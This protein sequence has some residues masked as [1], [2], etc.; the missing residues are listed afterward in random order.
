MSTNL[1]PARKSKRIKIKP[2]VDFNSDLDAQVISRVLEGLNQKDRHIAHAVKDFLENH[3]KELGKEEPREIVKRV[4]SEEVLD[5]IVQ[6]H[7]SG[8]ELAASRLRLNFA[9][10]KFVFAVD[11][12]RMSVEEFEGIDVDLEW[13]IN[14]H[15]YLIVKESKEKEEAAFRKVFEFSKSMADGSAPLSLESI[16]TG[17]LPEDLNHELRQIPGNIKDFFQDLADFLL[18]TGVEG[19]REMIRVCGDVNVA[20]AFARDEGKPAPLRLLAQIFLRYINKKE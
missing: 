18:E 6:M 2:Y 5:A 12:L 15:K 4:E 3:Q 19:R 10:K 8:I 7:L 13:G 16:S 17:D 20:R 14:V 1:D 11:R 9:E